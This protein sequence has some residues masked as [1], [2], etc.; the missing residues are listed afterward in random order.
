M[1]TLSPFNE[2]AYELVG[3]PGRYIATLS[4]D[5]REFFFVPVSVCGGVTL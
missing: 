5:D 3:D 2:T 1:E 4:G